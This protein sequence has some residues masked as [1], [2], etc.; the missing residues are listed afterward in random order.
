MVKPPVLLFSLALIATQAVAQEHIHKHEFK[1]KLY[2]KGAL[3]KTVIA[4]SWGEARNSPHEWGRTWEGFGKRLGSSYAQ[5]A[6]KG[7]TE[8]GISEITHEDLRYRKSNQEGALRRV[9]YAVVRTFWMP[10]D[11]GD[12]NTFAVGRVTGAFVA[13]QVARTW[14]P[15]RVATFGAGAQSAGLSLG[16]DAG[17]NI[18]REFWPKKH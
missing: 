6:I 4:A 14:M 5:R 3:I 13:G 7:A 16:L 11:V 18:V 15:D 10:R 2:F 9:K 12:G 8:F 1:N 17:L